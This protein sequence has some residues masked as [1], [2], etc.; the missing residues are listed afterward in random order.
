MLVAM[1][2]TVLPTQRKKNYAILSLYAVMAYIVTILITS[3]Q[4][5]NRLYKGGGSECCLFLFLITFL[6]YVRYLEAVTMYVILFE[7][8]YPRIF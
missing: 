3:E 7:F 6:I 8:I 2:V 5:Y 4:F 1:L